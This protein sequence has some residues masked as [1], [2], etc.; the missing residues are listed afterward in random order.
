MKK[1]FKISCFLQVILQLGIE[2]PNVGSGST[3]DRRSDKSFRQQSS[4]TLASSTNPVNTSSTSTGQITTN[5]RQV[6]AFGVTAKKV[7]NK[8]VKNLSSKK[9]FIETEV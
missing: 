2:T 1:I 4:A 8:S 3:N 6:T 9:V 7:T 5:S